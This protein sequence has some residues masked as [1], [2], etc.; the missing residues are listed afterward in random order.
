MRVVVM[1]KTVYGVD[2]IYPLC[3]NAKLFAD[4]AGTTTLREGD[5]SRIQR[6]GFEIVVNQ[7]TPVWVHIGNEE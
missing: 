2:K 3:P 1:V 5:L 7:P 6:L 4:I